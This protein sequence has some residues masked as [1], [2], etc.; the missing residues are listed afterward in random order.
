MKTPGD[1]VAAMLKNDYLGM[2]HVFF[3]IWG[4]GQAAGAMMLIAGVAATKTEVVRNARRASPRVPNARQVA[5]RA[6]A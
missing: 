5:D 2:G 6:S 3:V 4:L 1:D